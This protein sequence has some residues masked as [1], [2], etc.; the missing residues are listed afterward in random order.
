MSTNIVLVN[1]QKYNTLCT[2]AITVAGSI[3]DCM[4]RVYEN[5]NQVIGFAEGC[6]IE[7]KSYTT[8][9][10]PQCNNGA[11]NLNTES[12]FIIF[13]IVLVFVA[14]VVTVAYGYKSCSPPP[15]QT[16]P[17]EVPQPTTGGN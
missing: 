13:G 1:G 14:L 11:R 10:V 7:A 15:P 2:S 5:V 8:L 4:G 12:Y 3:S 17:A 16:E 9:V 6:T